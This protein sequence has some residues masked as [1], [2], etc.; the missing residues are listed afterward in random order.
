MSFTWYTDGLM[1]G[2]GEGFVVGLSLELSLGSSLDF[3]NLGVTGII[4]GIYLGKYFGFLFDSIWYINVC[5]P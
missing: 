2:T 4:L 1:I 5:G 3:P